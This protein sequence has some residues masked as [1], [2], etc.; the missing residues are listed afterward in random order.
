M[1]THEA[2][3]V[4]PGIEL[5]V[6]GG[7]NAL[8]PN[9]VEDYRVDLVGDA[10]VDLATADLDDWAELMADL[11]SDSLS[12]SLVDFGASESEV[13]GLLQGKLVLG[14]V[15]GPSDGL[16]FVDCALHTGALTGHGATLV[17]ATTRDLSHLCL[18][19][20]SPITGQLLKDEAAL[21]PTE[22]GW[23]DAVGDRYI[24]AGTLGWVEAALADPGGDDGG[25]DGGDG[26]GDGG[27]DGGTDTRPPDAGGAGA[28]ADVDLGKDACS[29]SGGAGG[30]IALVGLL[31]LF[32][33]RRN[34][35]VGVRSVS[36]R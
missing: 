26:G 4:H 15:S 24:A 19:Y 30:S 14:E 5:H 28:G 25:G 16:V 9:G 27:I 13:Q 29:V 10:W 23:M 21:D 12:D 36:G 34:A 6:L 35:A 17:E 32:S 22:N 20:A 11:V 8:M 3:G 31:A 2:T 7:A 33:R 18:L 1:A